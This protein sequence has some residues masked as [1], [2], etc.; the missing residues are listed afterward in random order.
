MFIV[1]MA[2][3]PGTGKSTLAHELASELGAVVL[4]K[5]LVRAARFGAGVEY[6]RE[7]DDLVC[8]E[9]YARIETLARVKE[10]EY[11]ILDGRRFSKRYQVDEL[12]ELALRCEASLRIIEC[13]CPPAVARARLEL[14]AQNG[15]HLAANR[16]FELY[17]K[18]AAAAH[19]VEG[20]KLVVDTD[21]ERIDALVERCLAFV[22]AGS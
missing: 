13:V 22:R 7:Q 8:R 10:V 16:N 3:L 17:T 15:A 9:M 11:V 4:D 14:D 18:L 19:E 1:A 12:R 21:K 5:D 2:G 6:S 20:D